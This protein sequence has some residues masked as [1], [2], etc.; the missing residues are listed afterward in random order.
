MSAVT[1]ALLDTSVV[2]SPPAAGFASISE[3]VAVSSVTLAELEYGVDATTDPLERRKRRERL[4][5]VARTLEVL[6][7]DQAAAKSYGLLANL[8]RSAGRDPRPRRLDLLIAATAERHGLPLATRNAG[9]F[10]HLERALRI[11]D[12]SG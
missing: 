10:R 12:V 4:E 2:I 3:L 1:R 9:D 5:A 11:L 6:P 7:F 8:V